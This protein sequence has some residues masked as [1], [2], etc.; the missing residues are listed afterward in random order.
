MITSSLKYYKLSVSVAVHTAHRKG[1]VQFWGNDGFTQVAEITTNTGK[2][3][4]STEM[5]LNI[6]RK[7]D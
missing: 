7:R 2:A 4:I 3:Y 1:P 5:H 6:P